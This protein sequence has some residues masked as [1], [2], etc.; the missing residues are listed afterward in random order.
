MIKCVAIKWASKAG[1]V[2]SQ[3][4]FEDVYG[5]DDEVPDTSQSPLARLIPNHP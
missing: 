5:L 1:L 3:A 4:V 2:A